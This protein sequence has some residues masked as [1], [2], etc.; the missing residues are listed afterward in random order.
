M[1]PSNREVTIRRINGDDR[2]QWL[3]LWQGYLDFY[4]AEVAVRVK[5]V[6]ASVNL[7][8]QRFP[9]WIQ[10]DFVLPTPVSCC[11]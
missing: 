5:V 11:S 1:N 9:L 8:G 10:P 2:A 7:C 4:R 6:V 3:A